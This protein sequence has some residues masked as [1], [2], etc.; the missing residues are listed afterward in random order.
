MLLDHDPRRC[1]WIDGD[2]RADGRQ[3]PE[4]A[5]AMRPYCQVHMRRAYKPAV[6]RVVVELDVVVSGREVRAIP[7]PFG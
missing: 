3:C 6:P 4:R 2:P 5:V 7:D 1:R